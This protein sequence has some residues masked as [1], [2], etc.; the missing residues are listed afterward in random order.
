MDTEFV[1]VAPI[2]RIQ[3]STAV[4]LWIGVVIRDSLASQVIVSAQ[5]LSRYFLWA[6]T[7][8]AIVIRQ[9]FILAQK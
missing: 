7:I 6:A 1:E 4:I 5:E 9:S 2:S 3:L 8:A